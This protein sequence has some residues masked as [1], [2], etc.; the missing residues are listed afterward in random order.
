MN[1]CVDLLETPDSSCPDF[2]SLVVMKRNEKSIDSLQNMMELSDPQLRMML[3]R[4]T[5]SMPKLVYL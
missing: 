2:I 3:F 5:E 1:S 4:A